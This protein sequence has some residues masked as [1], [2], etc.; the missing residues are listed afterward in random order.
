M[1][2]TARFKYCVYEHG[3]RRETLIDLTRDPGEMTNLAERPEHRDE[4]DRHRRLLAR[5][6]ERWGDSLARDYIV[7]PHKDAVAASQPAPG[8]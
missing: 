2:R 1:V 6:V 4:L 8:E 3:Q 5:W 7:R